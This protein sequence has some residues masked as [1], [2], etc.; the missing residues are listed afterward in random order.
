MYCKRF[1]AL[2]MRV[3]ERE[4]S[5][6]K[7]SVFLQISTSTLHRWSKLDLTNITP[8]RHQPRRS[9]LCQDIIV[10]LKALVEAMP[11]TSLQRL[12]QLM[13]SM[14]AVKLGRRRLKR[15]LQDGLKFSRKRTS[16]RLAPNHKMP[17]SQTINTFVAT[18]QQAI[19]RGAMLVSLDECYFS[20]RVLP[21][22]GYSPKGKP[23]IVSSPAS[24]WK[25]RSL[26]LAIASDGSSHHEI[27]QGS[28]NR[29]VFGDFV[30][31]LPYPPGTVILLDNVAFHKCL[32]VP[33]AD[34]GF[35]PLFTPPYSPQYNPVEN[36]F[37]WIKHWFRQ[38][39]PWA[40]GVDFAIHSAVQNSPC[41][42]IISCFKH[43]YSIL[44]HI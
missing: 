40:D 37:S 35:I 42:K 13:L 12:R 38:Q 6:R 18:A 39:W 16:R 28:V 17:T 4:G 14:H 8:R 15:L 41:E 30:Q 25:K 26:M 1:K 24:S 34:K 43:F 36:A 20:E 21:L 5:F 23:C 3:L 29:I 44:S 9:P 33:F 31:S 7:A 19:D 10:K 11:I 27:A 32:N 22:Y 2:A